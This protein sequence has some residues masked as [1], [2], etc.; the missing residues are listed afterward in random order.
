MLSKK[1]A[2]RIKNISTIG[3]CAFLESMFCST[4]VAMLH[5]ST[6][7]IIDLS[8]RG[9]RFFVDEAP[10]IFYHFHGLSN[11]Y[12]LTFEQ[13]GISEYLTSPNSDLALLL[14]KVYGPYIEALCRARDEAARL[15]IEPQ[16]A[17]TAR[18]SWS[19]V[20]PLAAAALPWR[21][22]VAWSPISPTDKPVWEM[23]YF[24]PEDR[25]RA[26]RA[27]MSGRRGS[28]HLSPMNGSHARFLAIET[29]LCGATLQHASGITSHTRLGR[30]A[31]SHT[32]LSYCRGSTRPKARE[33]C[34]CRCGIIQ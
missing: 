18:D 5:R 4:R 25:A 32:S 28:P 9:D 13:T 23:P 33:L 22:Y 7:R 12:E 3:R 2:S 16:A 17:A 8:W 11:W 34:R 21:E 20:A 10:L 31:R 27:Y 14:E 6:W 24:F 30:R 19:K 15:E 1:L 26:W 29:I